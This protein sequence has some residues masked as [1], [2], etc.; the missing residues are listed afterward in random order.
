MSRIDRYEYTDWRGFGLRVKNERKS[1]GL[2]KEKFANLIN[3]TENFIS[4]LEKGNTSCSIHTLHQIG[5]ALKIST[6]ELLYAKVENMDKT[7]SNK[8]ILVNIIEKC[9]NE[10]IQVLNDIIIA[11]YPNLEKIIRKRSEKDKK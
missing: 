11:T 3:R 5:K 2:S 9:N 4:E 7:Y 10:E 1:I 6:D 8:E